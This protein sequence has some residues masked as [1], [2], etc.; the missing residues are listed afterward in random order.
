MRSY[1]VV[2]LAVYMSVA[3]V[4]AASLAKLTQGYIEQSRVTAQADEVLETAES[5]IAMFQRAMAALN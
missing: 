2:G 4:A 5:R 1:A 3:Y